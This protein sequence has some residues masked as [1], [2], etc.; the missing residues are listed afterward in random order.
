M[1]F[2]VVRPVEMEKTVL[3]GGDCQTPWLGDEE[4]FSSQIV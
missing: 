2:V 1:L 3:V 4:N